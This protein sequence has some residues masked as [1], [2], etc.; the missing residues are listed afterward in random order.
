[1]SRLSNLADDLFSRIFVAV[2]AIV[3]GFVLQ[4]R[5]AAPK[6]DPT[7]SPT[8][9]TPERAP[10]PR[11]VHWPPDGER[12]VYLASSPDTVAFDLP[13]PVEEFS[14]Q[15]VALVY[16]FDD[17]KSLFETPATAPQAIILHKSRIGEV[18]Q[19]WLQPRYPTGL[20]I[21]GVNISVHELAAL[22]GDENLAHDPNYWEGGIEPF[23]SIVYMK[24]SIGLPCGS[25]E[26]E[27]RAQAG[28]AITC[29]WG[30]TT[31]KI[32]QPGDGDYFLALIRQYIASTSP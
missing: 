9:T 32:R 14:A 20:V 7:S 29:G 13:V 4:T 24:S 5:E 18:D 19:A 17:S 26:A 1:M 31:H 22:V 16:N 23:F 6:A 30:A 25:P 2:I 28:E 10:T 12:I 15:G 3:V 21:A 27:R 8:T 11:A